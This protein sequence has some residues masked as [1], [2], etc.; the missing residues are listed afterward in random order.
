MPSLAHHLT[1][2]ENMGEI[3]VPM[4]K[5]RNEEITDLTYSKPHLP[6][7]SFIFKQ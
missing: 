6:P 7:A 5:V 4:I 1:M 2:L 3:E